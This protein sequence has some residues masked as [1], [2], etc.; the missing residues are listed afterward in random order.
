MRDIAKAS[1]MSTGTVYRMFGSKDDLLVDIMQT[2]S[3][4]VA[5]A[6]DEVAQ[7][8]SSPLEQLDALMWVNINVL[9]RFSEEFKIQLAWLRQS[10]P[11]SVDLGLSFGRQ[12]RQ[13][14]DLLAAGEQA[15][16]LH[17]E[18]GSL[19]SRTRSLYELILTPENVILH[20][21]PRG[22]QTLA[23]DTVLRG[24]MVRR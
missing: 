12:L 17:V 19:L 11:S 7:S 22:A 20:A 21:G 18:G 10:P 24:A 6:W 4:N 13:L 15:G 3:E 9:T 14:Q 8:S 16:E 1:G 5:A 23:R 2:Y